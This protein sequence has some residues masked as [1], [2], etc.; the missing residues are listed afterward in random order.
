M[1][2]QDDIFNE[3]QASHDNQ[4]PPDDPTNEYGMLY[5]EKT[6]VEYYF[7]PVCEYQAPSEKFNKNLEPRFQ[8]KNIVCCPGCG[9]NLD[10]D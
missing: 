8:F 1:S 6:E 2:Q 4:L 7:C 9:A 5:A 10:G 3:M